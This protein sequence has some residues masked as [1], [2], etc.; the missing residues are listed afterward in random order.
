MLDEQ[1]VAAAQDCE[2]WGAYVPPPGWLLHLLLKT[3]DGDTC[4]AESRRARAI[5]QVPCG[6]C[7]DFYR[8]PNVLAHRGELSA[9]RL[10]PGGRWDERGLKINECSARRPGA[11]VRHNPDYYKKE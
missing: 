11:S 3:V 2:Q 7:F 1:E 5:G 8:P 9:R 10:A 4:N 6:R